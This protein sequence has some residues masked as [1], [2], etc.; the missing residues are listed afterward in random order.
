MPAAFGFSVGDLIRGIELIIEATHSLSQSNGAP[1]HYREL[2]RELANLQ[3]TIGHIQNLMADITDPTLASA[4]AAA[5]NDCNTCVETF[6]R[7][8]NKFSALESVQAVPWTFSG[9]KTRGR[10]VQ[11]ALGK[12]ADI[13]KFRGEI[14]LHVGN[15]DMLVATTIV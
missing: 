12:K 5:G 2:G 9:L 3:K 13:S 10:M 4:I 11:W 14:Q 6:M 8:N 1:A 15:L 7:R